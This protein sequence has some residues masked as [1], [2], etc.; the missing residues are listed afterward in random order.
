MKGG[1]SGWLRSFGFLYRFCKIPNPYPFWIKRSA[2]TRVVNFFLPVF[3][4]VFMVGVTLAIDA[5]STDFEGAVVKAGQ[6]CIPR[7]ATGF[8]ASRSVGRL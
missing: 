8:T 3:S 5:E 1:D 2:A 6:M 7:C 4:S